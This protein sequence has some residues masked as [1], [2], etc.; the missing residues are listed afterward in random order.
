M[1]KH[2]WVARGQLY[3]LLCLCVCVFVWV[4]KTSG[5]LIKMDKGKRIFELVA[6]VAIFIPLSFPLYCLLALSLTHA[7]HVRCS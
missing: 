1:C 5:I 7:V 6:L 3:L 2:V 4:C